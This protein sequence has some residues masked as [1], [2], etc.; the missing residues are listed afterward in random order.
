MMTAYANHLVLAGFF[1]MSVISATL[2]RAR[3]QLLHQDDWMLIV[4]ILLI[5]VPCVILVVS[6]S[7]VW[8]RNE[9]AWRNTV[10]RQQDDYKTSLEKIILDQQSVFTTTIKGMRDEHV[11]AIQ[12]M[13]ESQRAAYEESLESWLDQAFRQKLSDT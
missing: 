8:M 6:L 2:V 11:V 12:A 1:V 3:F 5:V 13:S 4:I 7:L 9:S 10:L